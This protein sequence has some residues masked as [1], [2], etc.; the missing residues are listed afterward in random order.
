MRS[1]RPSAT[2]SRH[3]CRRSARTAPLAWFA[4]IESG[5]AAAFA[6]EPVVDDPRHGRVEGADAFA[7]YVADV[8][9][10]LKDETAGL[11][12]PVRVTRSGR[13]SVEEVSV[14]L[15]GS[16]PELPVA[17]VSDLAD[18]GRLSAVRVYHS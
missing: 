1:S 16:H 9:A 5:A 17:V 11:I 15:T 7:A 14:R 8:R 10:W 18:D 4:D 6:G 3:T 2:C 12:E 13:R